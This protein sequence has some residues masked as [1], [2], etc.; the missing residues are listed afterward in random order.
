MSGQ[1]F[2][3]LSAQGVD[4]SGKN[5]QGTSFQFSDISGT[6]FTGANLKDAIFEGAMIY[7]ANFTNADLRG[8]NL[9]KACLFQTATWTGAMVDPKWEKI[10]ALF[11]NGQLITQDFQGYDLSL[12]CFEDIKWDK[13]NFSHANLE[14]AIFGLYSDDLTD[15]SFRYANLHSTDLG[16]VDL[17]NADFTGALF[18]DTNLK[19]ANLTGTQISSD[20][21]SKAILNDCTRLP[22]GLLVNESGCKSPRPTNRPP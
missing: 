8:A 6:N 5:L 17:T 3:I 14:F 1:D 11:E 19:V 13:P 18:L 10:I 15:A 4:L 22:N 9:N 21:L 2:S 7:N 12:V 16:V 20:Q